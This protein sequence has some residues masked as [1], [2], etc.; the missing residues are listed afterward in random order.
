MRDYEP[1]LASAKT[2]GKVEPVSTTGCLPAD[3]SAGHGQ[4]GVTIKN[5]IPTRILNRS[6]NFRGVAQLVARRVWDAEVARSNRV[7]PTRK[8]NIT[9]RWCYFLLWVTDEKGYAVDVRA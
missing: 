7:T 9:F 3:A 8:N 4:G 2:G 6:L 1:S 5:K